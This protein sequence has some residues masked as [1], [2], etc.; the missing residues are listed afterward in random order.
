MSL[1][2]D[3]KNIRQLLNI[4]DDPFCPISDILGD[5]VTRRPLFSLNKQPW[6]PPTDIYETET[7][8]LIKMELAGVKK[9]DVEIT[10]DHDILSIQ[11]HR[12]EEDP[13]LKK[14]YHLMEIHFGI[15]KR[16][17]KIPPHFNKDNIRAT[18]KDG[19]LEVSIIKIAHESEAVQIIPEED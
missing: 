7:A 18:Y 2:G 4:E 5:F 14:N 13:S 19:F 9:K 10:L 6:N 15:F 3:L 1:T 11:G 8:I 12:M 16:S 17:F